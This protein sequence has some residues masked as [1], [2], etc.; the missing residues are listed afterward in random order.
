[1]NRKQV[2]TIFYRSGQSIQSRIMLSPFSQGTSRQVADITFPNMHKYT[3]T[4]DGN[5]RQIYS[6]FYG[7]KTKYQMS[8]SMMRQIFIQICISFLGMQKVLRLSFLPK[9]VMIKLC[10]TQMT[11]HCKMINL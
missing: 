5:K 2:S 7:R 10:K 11:L 4:H 6:K 9:E 3:P 1:M 8:F